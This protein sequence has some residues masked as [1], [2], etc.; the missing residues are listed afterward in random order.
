MILSVAKFYLNMSYPSINEEADSAATGGFSFGGKTEKSSDMINGSAVQTSFEAELSNES[1][2]TRRSSV[3]DRLNFSRMAGTPGGGDRLPAGPPSSPNPEFREQRVAPDSAS[4][5]SKKVQFAAEAKQNALG[6]GVEKDGGK[7]IGR[8]DRLRL[9]DVWRHNSLLEIQMQLDGNQVT[10]EVHL[11]NGEQHRLFLN[12]RADYKVMDNLALVW[13]QDHGVVKDAL[14]ILC[15]RIE[16]ELQAKIDIQVQACQD[17]AIQA[18][19]E[20][21]YRV[22]Q[23]HY[24]YRNV[25]AKHDQAIK[26]WESRV[27]QGDEER[28]RLQSNL[29]VADERYQSM[30][31]RCDELGM[32]VEELGRKLAA[33]DEEL[34]GCLQKLESL[35]LQITRSATTSTPLVS[36]P[37]IPVGLGVA[38]R[39]H[40]RRAATHVVSDSVR[41]Y[42]REVHD[43]GAQGRTSGLPGYDSADPSIHENEVT[44]GEVQASGTLM[45]SGGDVSDLYG[46]YVQPRVVQATTSGRPLGSNEGV[47]VEGVTGLSVSGAGEQGGV[48]AS[49][50][51]PQPGWSSDREVQGTTTRSQEDHVQMQLIAAMSGKLAQCQ[52]QSDRMEEALR[53]V[54]MKCDSVASGNAVHPGQT[55]AGSVSSPSAPPV[56][57]PTSARSTVVTSVADAVVS[58]PGVTLGAAS[59]AFQ[60][61]QIK[62]MER[63]ID[64]F[65]GAKGSITWAAYLSKFNRHANSRKLS[66]ESRACVLARKLSG[67]ADAALEELSQDELGDYDKLVSALN[68]YF[69]PLQKRELSRTAL[70]ERLQG[71][72]ESPMDYANAIRKLAFGAYP[73]EGDAI[74]TRR[75]EEI[76]RLFCNGI[77][78]GF[79]RV[80]VFDSKPTKLM[81][82]VTAAERWLGYTRSATGG[83][84]PKASDGMVLAVDPQS[85]QTPKR[86]DN[87]RSDYRAPNSAPNVDSMYPPNSASEFQH[88]QSGSYVRGPAPSYPGYETGPRVPGPR[89]QYGVQRAYHSSGSGGRYGSGNFGTR[90]R[91]QGYRYG[92]NSGSYQGGRVRQESRL[93]EMME[94]ILKT[95]PDVRQQMDAQG[96][97]A[98]MKCWNCGQP[99]HFQREC[100]LR[101]RHEEPQDVRLCL[102][103]PSSGGV[104]PEEQAASS[105][106][107]SSSEGA[108]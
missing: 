70:E 96:Y 41:E 55:G 92:Y 69:M 44:Q 51:G 10:P 101:Y 93:M 35:D 26:E 59:F 14:N 78:D 38:P 50:R 34:K 6:A 94:A 82:A 23:V 28:S 65:T 5:Q 63:T 81:D 12:A 98:G 43:S 17:Q 84:L 24:K 91:G 107:P 102:E 61:G 54:S 45:T 97:G 104:R 30:A 75:N 42:L 18:K 29:V 58:A 105:G 11:L 15:G 40:R 8:T 79:Q 39:R 25:Q 60:E 31:A 56:P 3:A 95:H 64:S 67:D 88:P 27:S 73:G 53:A 103:L 80:Y 62:E 52:A 49:P 13:L 7:D 20:S 9:W 106:A 37:D 71:V 36:Q 1:V 89:P 100:P 21:E 19:H 85:A 57:V 77:D 16:R 22:G 72:G 83:R 86:T 66:Q 48:Q 90:G 76:V 2:R 108:A 4:G 32:Q 74:K 46:S 87:Y 68:N 33:R 47:A 99:G